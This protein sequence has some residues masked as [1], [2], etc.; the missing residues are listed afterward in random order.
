MHVN[1]IAVVVPAEASLYEL[2]IASHTRQLTT[3]CIHQIVARNL[4]ST[5]KIA[6]PQARDA[7]QLFVRGMF[8]IDCMAGDS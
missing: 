5:L 7:N 3:K 6:W 4:T 1:T 2:A 8:V